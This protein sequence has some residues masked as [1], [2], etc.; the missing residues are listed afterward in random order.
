MEPETYMAEPDVSLDSEL[1]EARFDFLPRLE[2]AS[3]NF[4]NI[5]TLSQSNV[6]SDFTYSSD[7]EMAEVSSESSDL[8]MAEVSSG[9]LGS[10][11]GASSQSNASDSEHD[12][13]SNP[14]YNLARTLSSA[15]NDQDMPREWL[16]NSTAGKVIGQKSNIH[17]QWKN[18]LQSKK[19]QLEEST[20]RTQDHDDDGQADDG[21]Y[22]PFVS[23]LDWKIAHWAVT[24]NISQKAFD[25]LLQVPQVKSLNSFLVT[26]SLDAGP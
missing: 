13:S 6:H 1:A 20:S 9:S 10:D 25:H 24:E 21:C 23:Q 14:S 26:C 22:K 2:P 12:P 3:P 16:W 7:L 15:D 8:D 4:D 11:I 5:S 18:I 17:Q 19:Q